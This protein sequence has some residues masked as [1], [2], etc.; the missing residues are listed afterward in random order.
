[1]AGILPIQRK[2]QNN[3]LTEHTPIGYSLLPNKD[4]VSIWVKKSKIE[5]IIWK[6][7][8][9]MSK[10]FLV[11]YGTYETWGQWTSCSKRCGG[12]KQNR[13]R[14]CSSSTM[15][16][17]GAA[18][19]ERSCNIAACAQCMMLKMYM[20]IFSFITWLRFGIMSSSLSFVSLRMSALC[21]RQK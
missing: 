2:K 5:I 17:D 16:C 15:P 6:S 7:D 21:K 14:K 12:G 19:E 11:G 18:T 1:M 9:E 3:Q 8:F 20:Y 10:F 4:N 13:A